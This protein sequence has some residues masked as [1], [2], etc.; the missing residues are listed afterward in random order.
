MKV[1]CKPTPV[2]VIFHINNFKSKGE[3]GAGDKPVTQLSSFSTSTIPKAK[4]NKELV[5]LMPVAIRR[6]P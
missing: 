2:I 3:Q 5:A 4:E 1:F 6:I